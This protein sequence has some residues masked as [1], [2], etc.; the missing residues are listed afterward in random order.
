MSEPKR[1]VGAERSGDGFWA[2]LALPG[3]VWLSVFFLLPFYVVL[4]VALGSVDPIL[5]TPRPEWNPLAWHVI[6]LRG[7]MVAPPPTAVRVAPGHRPRPLRH[8][9]RSLLRTAQSA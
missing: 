5:L 1:R 7:F 4:C 8:L 2:G 6:K 3:V 9:V